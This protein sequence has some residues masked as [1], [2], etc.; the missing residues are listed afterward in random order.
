MFKNEDDFKKLID[1]VDMNTEPNPAHRQNL[2]RQMLSVFNERR[3]SQRLD[4]VATGARRM[5]A[6]R[7]LQSRISKVAAAVIALALL[8]PLG[9]GTAA[10]IKSLVGSVEADS[11]KGRFTLDR[12]IH[13]NLQ[14]GTKQEHRIVTA[15][16]IRFFKEDEQL[17]GTLRCSVCSWPKFTWRTRVVLLTGEGDALSSTEHLREN[18]GVKPTGLPEWCGLSIHFSLG[19]W[20]E[21]SR[22]QAFRV[23]FERVPDEIETTADAWLESAQLPTVHGRVTGPSG[24]AIANATVQIRE[25]RKP[26][27]RGIAAPDVRTDNRGYYSFDGIEWPYRV[28]VLVHAE[29]PSARYYRHQYMRLNKVLEGNQAVD[30]NF[31]PFPRGNATL[32]GQAAEPNGAVMQEFR[33]DLRLKVDWKE[34]SGKYL[35]QFGIWKP[36]IASDGRFEIANLPAG[37][38]KVRLIPG[39]NE[40]INLIDAATRT[41]MRNY[42]CELVDGERIELSEQHALEKA[43]YGRVLFD[44]GTAAVLDS[45]A[46]RAHIIK[47]PRGFPGEQTLATVDGEGYFTACIS[48]DFMEQ[49]LS[50]R[51][52]LTIAVSHPGWSSHVQKDKFPAELLSLQR[53]KAGAVRVRRPHP[54][55]G[56]ILYENGKPAVPETPPWPGAKVYVAIR[57]AP[58]TATD[59]W[60]SIT[61]AVDSEGYFTVCLTDEELEHLRT[62]TYQI[63]IAHPSYEY[64]MTTYGIGTFPC[65]MLATEASQAKGYKLPY[66]DMS[67]EFNNLKQQLEST[68]KLE[69]LGSALSSYCADHTDS[70]PI[71]LEELRRYDVNDLLH[72]VKENVEYLG[73]G[74]VGTVH[75]GEEIAVVYD[76]TLLEKTKHRG[77]NVLFMDEHVEFCRA[78]RLQILGID[79]LEE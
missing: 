7:I 16:D 42:L 75:E 32:S 48:D 68:E 11:F 20:H 43:W 4:S 39:N 25:Q 49:L 1:S 18:G 14:V 69:E 24:E 64:S 79:C 70:F 78:R 27:Q 38:Y 37:L 54:Y 66:E 57:C 34:Y 46:V 2:R 13:I 47:W 53:D 55:Y 45:A 15:G 63:D 73:A 3:P 29:S 33:I 76:K 36:F 10:I 22:A 62:G 30:F 51:A 65:E 8:V 19:S 12:D 50:G 17:L 9:Y 77:T 74:Q 31:G 60:H 59:G 56:R 40:V 23:S 21:V 35:Y 61:V 5:V 44:D 67:V 28:G 71:S 52:W 41:R 58:A 26:G 6:R 72:W